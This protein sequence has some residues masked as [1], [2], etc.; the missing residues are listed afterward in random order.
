MTSLELPDVD[1]TRESANLS[2]VSRDLARYL[3]G[4]FAD[5]AEA[6]RARAAVLESRTT[7]AEVLP[8]TTLPGPDAA[9][10][11]RMADACDRVSA[12]FASV[13][14]ESAEAIQALVPTLER[15]RRGER[16]PSVQ[17]VYAGAVIRVRENLGRPAGGQA[18]GRAE[19]QR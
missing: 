13:D 15:Y 19:E 1:I 8:G 12:L 17:H 7:G 5:D 10:C 3:A 11:R 18:G 9:L 6:L 2:P 14:D 4:R 16:E